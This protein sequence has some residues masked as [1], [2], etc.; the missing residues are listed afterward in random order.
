MAEPTATAVFDAPPPMSQ[1]HSQSQGKLKGKKVV[2]VKACDQ[3]YRRK[4]KCDGDE[5]IKCSRCT[6]TGAA[7]T[8]VRRHNPELVR[9]KRPPPAKSLEDRI[10]AIEQM[11]FPLLNLSREPIDTA[12]DHGMDDFEE[13]NDDAYAGGASTGDL[14]L[15]KKPGASGW[16]SNMHERVDVLIKAIQTIVSSAKNSR[17]DGLSDSKSKD[18][19]STIKEFGGVDAIPDEIVRTLLSTSLDLTPTPLNVLHK[20][21]FMR[22]LN[23]VPDTLKFGLCAFSTIWMRTISI[24]QSD[25]TVYQFDAF[26]IGEVYFE[27]AQSTLRVDEPNF[28]TVMGLNYM[29]LYC[30]AQGK[31]TAS[32]MY[33]GMGTRMAKMVNSTT[34]PDEQDKYCNDRLNLIAKETRRRVFWN[35]HLSDLMDRSREGNLES[36]PPFTVRRPLPDA[37]FNALTED[38]YELPPSLIAHYPLDAGYYF[39]EVIRTVV[40][41]QQ[42]AR[43]VNQ[44]KK[45][46]SVNPAPSDAAFTDNLTKLLNFYNQMPP[47][48]VNAPNSKVFS[49]QSGSIS[50]PSWVAIYVHLFYHACVIHLHR[51]RLNLSLPEDSG[52]DLTGLLQSESFSACYLAANTITYV[53]SNLVLPQRA[54]KYAPPFILFASIQSLLVHLMGC[55]IGAQIGEEDLTS[56]S[57]YGVQVLETFLLE[58]GSTWKTSIGIVAA[59][60]KVMGALASLA[61]GSESPDE[62]LTTVPTGQIDFG[63]DVTKLFESIKQEDP[64][65]DAHLTDIM[66]PVFNKSGGFTNW[67]KNI[68]AG[69]PEPGVEKLARFEK[70]LNE[71]DPK[72][73]GQGGGQTPPSQLATPA[74]SMPTPSQTWSQTPLRTPMVSPYTTADSFNALP[75]PNSHEQ[76]NFGQ[77]FS[78]LAASSSMSH[79]GNQEPNSRVSITDINSLIQNQ[80]SIMLQQSARPASSG[81]TF[82]DASSNSSLSVSPAQPVQSV[83]PLQLAS[84]MG[85][86]YVNN[87]NNN[88]EPRSGLGLNSTQSFAPTPM[89]LNNNMLLGSMAIQQQQQAT[90][91]APQNQATIYAPQNQLFDPMG[92]NFSVP[93]LSQNAPISFNPQAPTNST[94]FPQFDQT[95]LQFMMQNFQTGGDNQQTSYIQFNKQN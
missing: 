76:Q 63:P 30:M 27:R 43:Q 12:D 4:L 73:K 50:P 19:P 68:F 48:L 5:N 82:R 95:S 28:E 69:S 67:F 36:S 11:L 34:D 41:I 85:Q 52:D 8:Y 3:C 91:Y 10:K 23:K 24:P 49:D 7:C 53:I 72:Q 33:N 29:A 94:D 6:R 26:D 37:L 60:R 13:G 93:N 61:R 89:N 75:E 83:T 47:W 71:L 32:W 78:P 57:Q 21:S 58:L 18:P 46:P 2:N 45:N 65:N 15:Q 35:M 17:L 86:L 40:G 42:Y 38:M 81:F 56:T 74:A 88:N 54:T 62:D 90:M 1:S 92:Q 44:H 39:T 14:K 77:I 70:I 51:T 9:N 20:T 59:M 22:S 84:Y 66:R 31:L 79:L 87:P 55:F 80:L 16:R 25:G 64:M